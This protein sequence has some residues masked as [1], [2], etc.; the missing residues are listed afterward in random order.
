MNA[1]VRAACALA[2]LAASAAGAEPTPV[3]PTAAETRAFMKELL[4]TVRDLH[5]KRD[6]QSPQVGMVY[7]YVD[8][9]KKGKLG[10]WV[11]GEALDTMH[12]GAWLAAALAQ[13]YRA[14]GDREYSDFLDRW[15]LPF[16]L[17][18]LNHSDELFSPERDDSG[19][20]NPFDREHLLQKG[21]KGFV[22][23]WWDDGAS[24]SLEGRHRVGGKAAYPCRDD[25]AGRANPEG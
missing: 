9:T 24:L 12:D 3:P 5:L 18:M 19:G 7:E 17:K 6:P 10:Q 20:K 22:P 23:Y 13:A 2:L 15:L 8:V 16:Y 4:H 21:E 14:T 11:Q 1:S 25:L